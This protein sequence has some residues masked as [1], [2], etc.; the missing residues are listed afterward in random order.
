MNMSKAVLGKLKTTKKSYN[1]LV[2]S[3]RSYT[4]LH[5]TTLH[6]TTLHYTI[7][8]IAGSYELTSMRY[9]AQKYISTS[10]WIEYFAY[11]LLAT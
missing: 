5:Y 10:I 8:L 1:G 3:R 4:T 11:I 6:Y 9:G 2:L 7:F